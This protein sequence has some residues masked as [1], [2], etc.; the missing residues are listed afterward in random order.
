[1]ASG[2]NST[3]RQVGFAAGVAV[4]RLV[5][6][7]TSGRAIAEG[8]HGATTNAAFAFEIARSAIGG[9]TPPTMGAFDVTQA[10]K[11]GE[12]GFTRGMTMIALVAASTALVAAALGWFLIRDT[13]GLWPIGAAWMSPKGS[14]RLASL[15]RSPDDVELLVT[16]DPEATIDRRR[17]QAF[18]VLAPR[19]IERLRRFGELRRFHDGDRLFSA[20]EE[21]PG[22]FVVLAG[23]VTVTR[24]DGL[25]GAIHVADQGPGEFLAE[26]GQ[27]SAR[28][29]FVDGLAAGPVEALLIAPEGIR[30]LVIAEA[31]LGERI[32]RAL[33]LR[34]V[35][36]IEQGSGA[37]LVGDVNAHDIV[38]LAGFLTRNGHPLSVVAPDVDDPA[39]RALVARFARGVD[40]L[41]LVLCP[42]GKVLR[43]PSEGDLARELGMIDPARIVGH[44][45][46]V[47]VVGAGPAGLAAAV[48]ASSEGLSVVVLDTYAFGGQAG[49]SAR[50]ENLLGFPTGITGQALSARAFVQAQKFGAEIGIPMSASRLDCTSAD[51][52]ALRLEVDGGGVLTARTVVLA[53]GASYRRLEVDGMQRFEGRGIAYWASPLEARQVTG[54]EVLL[55]GGGNSAGQAAVYLAEHARRVR[56]LVRRP[57]VETMS[58]YL[59]ERIAS[60]SSIEV[61]EGA[62]VVALAG[63]DRLESVRWRTPEGETEEPVRYLFLFIGAEPATA[64][65][66]GCGVLLERGFVATGQSLTKD[67]LPDRPCWRARHPAPHE[68]SVPGVFAIGDVRAGSVKRVGA[69]IGEGAAVVAQLHA[70]LVAQPAAK[71]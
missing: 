48:Y 67:A 18:P 59:V 38:R 52:G 64:W 13:R 5:L 9:Q 14:D 46:D 19:D 20:G 43:N 53:S 4:L 3:M 30:A 2:I 39:A 23:T 71:A 45:F 47:A 37:V 70:H 32:M 25:G 65:L 50:I 40:D 49:A 6:T 7:Y 35:I 34:R 31:E 21:G 41:P 22:M 15:S 33:I 12:I 62:A 60:A 26:V 54:E 1:M 44:S 55:V 11:L 61:V 16:E 28:P 24:R 57:L 42:N 29:A 63:D 36:L 69:A 68:T 66:A 8:L 17:N 10:T 27:L 56:I 51:E 58:E